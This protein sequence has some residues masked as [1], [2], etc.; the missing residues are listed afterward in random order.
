MEP[1]PLPSAAKAARRTIPRELKA[2]L[3]IGGALCLAVA[4]VGLFRF[5]PISDPFPFAASENTVMAVSFRGDAPDVEKFLA[6]LPEGALE[7]YSRHIEDITAGTVV[8]LA[9]SPDADGLKWDIDLGPRFRKSRL[10]WI[11]R[12]SSGFGFLAS[13]VDAEGR[14]SDRFPFEFRIDGDTVRM[15][16]GRRFV[17]LSGHLGDDVWPQPLRLQGLVPDIYHQYYYRPE[18]AALPEAVLGIGDGLLSVNPA[19]IVTKER[20]ATS[21]VFLVHGVTENA[22][23][24]RPGH[25]KSLRAY[26]GLVD[27]AGIRKVLPDGTDYLERRDGAEYVMESTRHLSVGALTRL[28]GAEGREQIVFFEEPSGEYW[29]G[30][31]LDAIQSGLTLGITP[32][33]LPSACLPRG[34]REGFIFSPAKIEPKGVQNSWI[35]GWTRG[36]KLVSL[37]LEDTE[38]GLFTVCGKLR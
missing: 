3:L 2:L 34:Q 7:T 5:R 16:A 8:T 35:L 22:T 1:G 10:R 23:A 4:A 31:S 14:A 20:S 25:L 38:A 28:N 12:E 29:V 33:T 26:L 30:Q 24:T 27:P 18:R 6:A 37:V 32:S 15:S 13:G 17:G 36:F 21:T 19:E 9:A 11:R